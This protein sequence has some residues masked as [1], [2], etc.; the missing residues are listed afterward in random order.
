MTKAMLLMSRS[1]RG[2]D[3]CGAARLEEDGAAVRRVLK[4]THREELGS[5]LA[6]RAE[7][8]PTSTLFSS[9][10]NQRENYIFSLDYF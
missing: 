4:N 7:F 5:R 9:T 6:P 3:R 1:S 2:A 8:A 10:A